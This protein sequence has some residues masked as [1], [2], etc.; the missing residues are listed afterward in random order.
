MTDDVGQLQALLGDRYR[1]EREIARGG[2]ATVYLATDLRHDRQVALKVMH[3]EVALAL[4]RERFLR[5]IRLTAKLSH[6]NI[7]TVHDSGEAGDRLWYVMP[8]VEGETLRHR[9]EKNGHLSVDESLRL[10][11]EAAE[12]IGYAHSLGVVHR[13]IKPENILLSRGHAVIADFGIARAIDAARDDQLTAAGAA[14]GTTAYMSPEQ[15]LAEE[16][17][18]RADVWALGCVLYETLSGRPPFGSGGREV[19]TRS[20]TSRPDSLREVRPEIPEHVEHIVDKA[21]ARDKSNRFANAAEFADALEEYRTWN[22]MPVRKV[23]R[24]T[25]LLRMAIIITLIVVVAG[26]IIVR[27]QRGRS[28]AESRRPRRTVLSADSIARDFYQKGKAQQ[29]RRTSTGWAN[30]IALYSQAVARDSSFALAWAD[31]ARTANFA[32]TRGSGVPGISNDSLLALALAASE[33]AVILAPDDPV[34][35]LV[36][37][38]TA[39]LMDP[40]DNRP[41]IFG[42]RKS[43]ALDSTYVPA[44]HELGITMQEVF[45]DSAALASWQHA[46]NLDPSNTETLSFIALHYLWTGEYDRGVKWA[47]SAMNLDPTYALAREA[48]GQLALELGKPAE[49]QRQFEAEAKLTSGREQGNA[50]AMIGRALAA[51][52]KVK[53]AREY[54]ERAEGIV[55]MKHPVKHEAAYMGAALAAIGD[56]AG[57]VRIMEA[58]EPRA[59]MHFQLHLKRDPGLRWLKGHWGKG[60]LMPDP[61]KL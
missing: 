21:L 54:V 22:V 37:G 4:G 58:Y 48:A 40:T 2:M 30:A 19:L 28:P 32:Y 44:W 53:E 56:T 36:K 43:L 27:W 14:I 15:S 25:G 29:V 6:P 35:W 41:R 61:G 33:R 34:T 20:L 5:E 31:L 13:D 38:R 60:L 49:S 55:D 18:A 9:L 59:D 26:G 10:I 45:D 16:I 17:D 52:G 1:I 11:R 50:F 51:Q 7:L 47:D 8:Y 42:I 57:A 39:F 23:P 3:S 24:S 12:A 46:A